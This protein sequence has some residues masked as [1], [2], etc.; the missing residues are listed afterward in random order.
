MAILETRLS[1]I[2]S[3]SLPAVNAKARLVKVESDETLVAKVTSIAPT[4][5]IVLV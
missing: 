1:I 4:D 5:D 2:L 3:N